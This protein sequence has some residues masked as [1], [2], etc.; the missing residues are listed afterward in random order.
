MPADPNFAHTAA[1]IGD[2]TRASILA[3]L[4]GGRA[5]TASELAHGAGVSAQTASMHLARLV[6]GG[7]LKVITSGRHRYYELAS[8]QVAQVLETLA[9]IA[10]PAQVQS[11]RQSERSRAIR[12]AR[13]CYDH[14]AGVVGVALTERLLERALITQ[15]GQEFQV[16]EAGMAWLMRQ[17]IDSERVMHRRRVAVRPC[18]DWSERRYHVAGA[19]GAALFEWCLAQNWFVRLEHSRALRLTEA[20]RAGFAR[21]WEVLF[22]QG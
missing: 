14:L 18:L 3:A 19:F 6:E 13:S 5:L 12:F 15:S 22:E 21:E 2:S 11:L 4:L 8:L 20:G 7:L 17:G 16:T 10:P 1:L 9:T